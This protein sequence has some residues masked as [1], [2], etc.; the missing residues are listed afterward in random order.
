M[1]KLYMAVTNYKGYDTFMLP[2]NRKDKTWKS[3]LGDIESVLDEKYLE[4]GEN[5]DGLTLEIKFEWADPS[6]IELIDE[7]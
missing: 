3:I 5:F 2:V 4:N 1:Q 6:D 7:Y